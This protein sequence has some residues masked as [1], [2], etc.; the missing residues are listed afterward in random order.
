MALSADGA[1]ADP[2]GQRRWITSQE[3]RDEVHHMRGGADAIAVGVGTIIADDPE[4]TVRRRSGA[5]TR[6]SPLPRLPLVRVIF[7]SRLRMP[8][9]S[10]VVET[11]WRTPTVVVATDPPVDARAALVDRGV[12]VLEARDLQTA[13][14][15]LRERGIRSL[16]L[17]GGATLAGS[18]LRE[19]LVDRIAIFRSP[20]TLG[21]GALQAL[22][23][24]APGTERWLASLPVVTRRAFGEDTL[25][26]YA[27]REV[28]CSRE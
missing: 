14:R 19:K 20:V 28:P 9:R 21:P 12:D 25:I 23:H 6:E 3:S 10:M 7:D 4:L 1:I 8:T 27:V 15:L 18:F 11:A 26:T 5:S 17:E 13:L 22:A 24:A 2:T 16:F